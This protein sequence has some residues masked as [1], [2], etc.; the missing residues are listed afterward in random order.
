M[1]LLCPHFAKASRGCGRTRYNSGMVAPE[2]FFAGG[3][4]DRVFRDGREF[5]LWELPRAGRYPQEI[6][7]EEG[8]LVKD[9]WWELFQVM[10]TDGDRWDGVNEHQAGRDGL[11]RLT[12]MVPKFGEPTYCVIHVSRFPVGDERSRYLEREYNDLRWLSGLFEHQ[13]GP[14]AR[15]KYA[16][17]RPWAI[18]VS[19]KFR[20]R[21]HPYV[22]MPFV[23]QG[24]LHYDFIPIGSVNIPF[25][26][27]A[28]PYNDAMEQRREQLT[29]EVR[30]DAGRELYG[31]LARDL[32]VFQGLIYHVTEGRM[33]KDPRVNAGDWMANIGEEGMEMTLI[34]IH[35]GFTDAV[36]P[37]Q[38]V[39]WMRKHEERC[40][41]PYYG[42]TEEMVEVFPREWPDEFFYDCLEEARRLL[43]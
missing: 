2:E 1:I 3:R 28:M 8:C 6:S 10:F 11:I 22:I 5:G 19:G 33:L 35:D 14:E 12:R 27:Y 40:R 17:M 36:S 25:F 34:A 39:R 29:R 4:I 32:L 13:V 31:K 15:E 18:G 43:G 38:W 7:S 26:R 20:E 24:E 23:E 9:D 37:A 21:E 16:V 41:L 42:C 30:T